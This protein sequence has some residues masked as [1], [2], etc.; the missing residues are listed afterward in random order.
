[1]ESHA[2][3]SDEGHAELLPAPATDIAWCPFRRDTQDFCFLTACAHRP[4]QLWDATD[5][6][7]RA[8]Y[9]AQNDSGYF[10]HPT[11][12]CWPSNAANYHH[13]IAGG[14]GGFEDVKQVRFFDVVVEGDAATWSYSS[15]ASK[16]MVSVLQDC[17][18]PG[19]TA[20]MAVGFYNAATIDLIDCRN[21]C[22]AAVLRGL[23]RGA[24]V[25]QSSPN[26]PYCIYASGRWGDDR[27]LCWDLRRP[28][29]PLRTLRRPA[30]TPQIAQFHLLPRSATA[31][32]DS[33]SAAA[34]HLV[35]ASTEG[36]ILMY[37]LQTAAA[38][39]SDGVVEGELLHEEIGPTS[40]LAVVSSTRV[41][42]ATGSRP[43]QL[44]LR[45]E[46]TSELHSS[47]TD[48]DERND[49]KAHFTRR[50]RRDARSPVGDNLDAS[51]PWSD[52]SE[53]SRTGSYFVSLPRVSSRT[54][55]GGCTAR[56]SKSEEL[57]NIALLSIAV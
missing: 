17:M 53:G 25:I 26:D 37:N 42:V 55:G 45:V 35:S 32:R 12:L 38:M 33:P 13:C 44:P 16:G 21:R 27:I 39:G 14:Y 47:L 20:L 18:W 28:A 11:A 40:G 22:P 7:L 9:V 1:M 51:G 29:H 52:D 24:Q 4:I 36:G 15:R 19:T 48:D 41:A 34:M 30:A 49:M 56:L 46:A 50:R 57:V 10:A 31:S 6:T 3:S 23:R 5:L 43:H 2:L 54:G 8:S